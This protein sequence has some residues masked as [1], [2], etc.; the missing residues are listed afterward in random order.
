MFGAKPKMIGTPVRCPVCQND[1]LAIDIWCESCGTPLD[2]DGHRA[3]VTSRA[4]R[5][6]RPPQ[7]QGGSFLRSIISGTRSRS[8]SSAQSAPTSWRSASAAYPSP[9]GEPGRD[10]RITRSVGA[11]VGVLL[12]AVVAVILLPGIRGAVAAALHLNKTTAIPAPHVIHLLAP[13]DSVAIAGL[14]AKTGLKFATA[15]CS[16][17]PGCLTFVSETIGQDAAAVILA[18]GA[19]NG[20]QCVGY[21]YASGGAWHFLD[22]VCGL[23]A[24]LSPL[25]GRDAGI[26]TPGSC[27]NVRKSPSPSAPIVACLRDATT[28]QLDGGPIFINGYLWW[29]EP[30]GW[31]AHNFLVGS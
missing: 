16:P 20:R 18:T 5:D 9:G 4:V 30:N 25:A 1:N 15:Q 12:I 29:H 22:S 10:F 8:L 27:G 14:E 17:N 3:D 26:K 31:I 24:Q 23:P 2:W 6:V 13:P 19:A 21:T 7:P 11:V 28:V